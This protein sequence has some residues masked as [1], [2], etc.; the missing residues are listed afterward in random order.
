M[1]VNGFTL[2]GL[3]TESKGLASSY[4]GMYPDFVFGKELDDGTPPVFFYHRIS[5]EVFSHHLEHLKRNGY[6]TLSADQLYETLMRPGLTDKRHLV[7][8]FDDGLDDLYAVVYPLLREFRFTAV[9]YI[10]PGWVGKKGFVTWDQ[11]REM[12]ESGL[13]DFQSHSMNH[14]GVFTSPQ[15]IDFIHPRTLGAGT[16]VKWLSGPYSGMETHLGAPTYEWASRLSDR[17][18]YIPDERIKTLCTSYVI[19]NGCDGFFKRPGWRRRLK[20]LITARKAD[21][22]SQGFYET[23]V[24][25][26][27]WIRYEIEESKRTIENQLPGKAVKHFAF[28]WHQEGKIATDLL[29]RAGYLTLGL[30]LCK[31][32]QH[33]VIKYGTFA[34]A[35]VN[36]DFVPT[37]P[38]ATRESFW[39]IMWQKAIRR[40]KFATTPP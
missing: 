1:K 37:L 35:R 26:E 6:S 32:Y 4:M 20:N 39:A 8:T 13:I 22:E 9:A 17:L 38:G 3:L 18:R 5:G 40:G 28:P 36:G 30:G 11:V 19:D 16:E 23:E 15:I 31:G 14:S 33:Q 10:V 34:V 25:Q 27:R 29:L 7:L 12:H 21:K 2:R 24:E